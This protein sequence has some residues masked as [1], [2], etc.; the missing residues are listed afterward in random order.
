MSCNYE[1][2][3]RPAE[4]HFGTDLGMLRFAEMQDLAHISRRLATSVQLSVV[5]LWPSLHYFR[6]I[7]SAAS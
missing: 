3:R 1:N 2:R 7:V 4:E 5:V 6:T